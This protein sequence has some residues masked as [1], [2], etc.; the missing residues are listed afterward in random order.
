MGDWYE[1]VVDPLVAA[2]DAAALS[3]RV[4]AGLVAMNLVHPVTADC[5][6]GAPGYPPADGVQGFLRHPDSALMRLTTNGLSVVA[7]RAAH[8]T[9][10]LERL[11]CP[12]CAAH[13][14]DLERLSWQE[15]VGDWYDGGLGELS[16][17]TCLARTSVD[18]WTH[19]PACGFGNLAFTFWNWPPFTQ[20]YWT[21]S[22]AQVI[23]EVVG[24]RCVLVS[25][26]L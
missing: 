26:K 10:N 21:K 15:A 14:R 19:E 6:L 2:E 17:P 8:V 22:P 9:T 16:C 20:E 23:E 11:T 18:S 12:A 3:A 25:G 13:T 4:L 1:T 7:K 5:A 24:H